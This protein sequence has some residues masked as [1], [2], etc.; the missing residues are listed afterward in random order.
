[1]GRYIRWKQSY[2]RCESLVPEIGYKN[3]KSWHAINLKG[4]EAICP[5]A[6]LFKPYG[7]GMTYPTPSEDLLINLFLKGTFAL[8]CIK[9][10][11]E[12]SLY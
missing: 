12:E 2:I 6:L 11:D 5:T 3:I 9:I 7:C 1:M 10:K 4:L 8:I